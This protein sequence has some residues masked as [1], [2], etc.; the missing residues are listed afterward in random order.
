[1]SDYRGCPARR[2]GSWE[3]WGV[4]LSTTGKDP[5]SGTIC[6]PGVRGQ[7]WGACGC[8][9][10]PFLRGPSPPACVTGCSCFSPSPA[11]KLPA[12]DQLDSI[13]R[14]QT[15]GAVSAGPQR[16]SLPTPRPMLGVPSQVKAWGATTQAPGRMA[17]RQAVVVGM[18]LIH[19]PAG[20][21]PWRA[22]RCSGPVGWRC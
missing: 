9:S 1:M 6:L 20:S 8:G 7:G 2:W 17:P 14:P 5:T 21:R 19:R 13:H 15:G 11:C 22:G 16:P 12:S 3:M 10:S 18:G 4:C